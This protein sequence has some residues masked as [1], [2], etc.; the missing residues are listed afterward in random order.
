MKMRSI[1]SN[2]N[3]DLQLRL[4]TVGCYIFTLLLYV[5]EAWTLKNNDMKKDRILRAL[6]SSQNIKNIVDV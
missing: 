3:L 5:E 2:K 4:N 6:G 1:V